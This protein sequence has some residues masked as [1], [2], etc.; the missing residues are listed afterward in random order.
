MGLDDYL[1]IRHCTSANTG[2]NTGADFNSGSF[3]SDSFSTLSFSASE[4]DSFLHF[5]FALCSF[6]GGTPPH[7]GSQTPFM[8][9]K[10]SYSRSMGSITYIKTPILY[11]Y[12]NI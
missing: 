1:L 12:T 5:S 11:H 8:T 2:A 10:P 9:L 3:Y 4:S 6:L 7:W